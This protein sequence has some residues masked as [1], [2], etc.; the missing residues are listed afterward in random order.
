M[1]NFIESRFKGL[2]TCFADFRTPFLQISF[3]RKK[4]G[5]LTQ[6]QKKK[7]RGIFFTL[8]VR[9]FHSK[10]FYVKNNKKIFNKWIKS[11]NKINF[12]IETIKFHRVRESLYRLRQNQILRQSTK[13]RKRRGIP[14]RFKILRMKNRGPSLDLTDIPYCSRR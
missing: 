6:L 10:R 5:S 4:F 14:I 8:R 13:R 12:S 9:C 2:D 3:Y 11:S 1:E 7:K